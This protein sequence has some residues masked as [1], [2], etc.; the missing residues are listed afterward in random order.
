[1][2]LTLNHP[3]IITETLTSSIIQK[4]DLSSYQL[5]PTIYKPAVNGK[6]KM[7]KIDILSL[8]TLKKMSKLKQEIFLRKLLNWLNLDMK[9]LFMNWEKPMKEMIWE[10]VSNGLAIGKDMTYC[11]TISKTMEIRLTKLPSLT[12]HP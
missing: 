7:K 5:E 8:F 11:G 1:M 12:I 6:K 10:M 2:D 4:K 3:D 9:K